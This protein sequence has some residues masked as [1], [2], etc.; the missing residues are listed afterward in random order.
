[1]TPLEYIG[2]SQILREKT[3][4]DQNKY[5]THRC[6]ACIYLFNTISALDFKLY[7]L[8]ISYLKNNPNRHFFFF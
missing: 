6:I 5:I 3:Q 7:K 4:H 1:M 2:G 8:F